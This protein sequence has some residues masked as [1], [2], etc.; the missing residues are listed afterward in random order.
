M[1]YFN[2]NLANPFSHRWENIKSRAYKLS[3]HKYVELEVYKDNTIVS[4]T[5]RLTTRTD[6]AGLML[7]VG[8]LGYTGS[9]NFY[10]T[11]HWNEEEG[12][13]YIYDDAGYPT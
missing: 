5:L 3:R 11:R 1:I 13:Y 2:F 12:R 8:L 4:F 6:H 9:F 7:D 10:D